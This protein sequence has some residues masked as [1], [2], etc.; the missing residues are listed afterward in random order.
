MDQLRFITAGSVDDGKSTLIG[1]LLYDTKSL[2]DDTL[3]SLE[4]YN[5][6]RGLAGVDL[7]LVTDGLRS[8]REQGITIDVAYR[9]FATPKRKFIIADTPGH[10]QY[11]RNMVTGASTV[12]LAV[13]LIDATLGVQVQSRRHGF[14]A[15]LLGI[16]H[17]V[18]AVNKMD[19][20]G[21]SQPVFDRIVEEYSEFCQKLTIPDL[22]FVPVSAL[23]GD[24]VVEPSTRMPWYPGPTILH[25]LETVHVSSDRNLIDFRFPVQ[26]VIRP[27]QD[28]RG[29]AGQIASG[30]LAVG[31][32]VLVLPSRKR[33]SVRTILHSEREVASASAG[34][35]VVV[36][37]DHDIDI[38]R[39]DM[40]VRPGNQPVV[41]QELDAIVCWMDDGKSLT[42]GSHYLVLQTT[43]KTRAV[44]ERIHYQISVNTLHREASAGLSLNQI[45][46]VTLRTS[47]PLAYDEYR[48]NRAT[49]GFLLVDPATLA[50]VGAGMLRPPQKGT[51]DQTQSPDIV[52]DSAGVNLDQRAHRNRHRPL[53]IWMTGLS[54]SGKS[55]LAGMVEGHLFDKGVSV[56][57]LDGDNLRH[58]LCGDL[59][60]SEADRHENL[61]RAGHVARLLFGYGH[62]VLCTFISP[63]REDR[64]FIRG[65]FAPGEFAEVYVRATLE[66]CETRDPKGLYKKARAGQVRFMTGIDSP[67]EEP[68]SPE[69]VLDTG[70]HSAADLAR[71]LTNHIT[72]MSGGL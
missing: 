39:G 8:E 26:T 22:S 62:V 29:Y 11:T 24:N 15:S 20:V 68:G 27:H 41:S 64:D 70:L 37:L 60:F 59:G 42:P 18:V 25:H 69:L 32:E 66:V 23:E 53:V 17:V 71:I 9:Y 44:V 10:E 16:P 31:D 61:K 57:R 4:G 12:D 28:F 40:L 55:T 50:T 52:W 48:D 43:R 49:G 13:I 36:T 34:Q 72:G 14:L 47:E 51:S 65:L 46:R 33:A 56:V 21:W 63:F 19:L 54:G 45:G 38:G 5:E 7:A 6:R 67:Y 2:F 35:S 58:G 1:R 30:R 3:A